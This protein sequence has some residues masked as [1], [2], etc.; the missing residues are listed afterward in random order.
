MPRKRS[1]KPS[2]NDDDDIKMLSDSARIFYAVLW[3]HM[4][5][6]GLIEESLES[7]RSKVFPR[8]NRPLNEIAKYVAELAQP[9]PSG[10]PRLYRFTFNGKRLLHCATL[11]KHSRI[12]SDEPAD[13]D[14][15]PEELKK[16]RESYVAGPQT[17]EGQPDLFDSSL[18][19]GDRAEDSQDCASSSASSSSFPSSSASALSSAP[20]ALPR[21]GDNFCLDE[22]QKPENPPIGVP[23][24]PPKGEGLQSIIN[25]WMR[26][27]PK[28]E[29]KSTA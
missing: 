23:A 22:N 5:R 21:V 10:R 28:V 9:G 17:E 18:Q 15:S 7:L 13:Y 11:G 14:I 3:C 26:G 29:G 6:N 20:D 8:E 19:R 12:W 24:S 1:I 2:F 16:I 4:D 25:R 27:A